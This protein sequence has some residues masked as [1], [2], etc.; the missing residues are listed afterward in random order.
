MWKNRPKEKTS[1]PSGTSSPVPWRELILAQ[2]GKFSLTT[3]RV[4]ER[5]EVFLANYPTFVIRIRSADCLL[6]ATA[7]ITMSLT[8]I[9]PTPPARRGWCL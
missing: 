8:W 2:L 6:A 5:P 1:E 4:E 7:S 9:T 3:A